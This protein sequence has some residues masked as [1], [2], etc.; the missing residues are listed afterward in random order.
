[1]I[2]SV[3]YMQ[4]IFYLIIVKPFEKSSENYILVLN[5]LLLL[6]YFLPIALNELEIFR[7]DDEEIAFTEIRIVLVT[8]ILNAFLNMFQAVLSLIAKIRMKLYNKIIKIVPVQS[9]KIDV[10]QVKFT[11]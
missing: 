8:L 5:E 9:T 3:I 4:I 1:M 10:Q 7:F 6:C 2:I 11:Q